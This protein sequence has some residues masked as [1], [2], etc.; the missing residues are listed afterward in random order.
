MSVCL[1]VLNDCPLQVVLKYLQELLC[2]EVEYNDS[3][4]SVEG[5]S[6]GRK[7]QTQTVIHRDSDTGMSLHLYA[8]SLIDG[9]LPLNSSFCS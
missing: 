8:I 9:I 3:F 7:S 1:C 6:A 2:E 5:T 4:E